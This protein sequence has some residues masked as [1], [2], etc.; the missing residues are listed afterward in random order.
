MQFNYLE[1]SR[2]LDAL[3]QAL[4]SVAAAFSKTKEKETAMAAVVLSKL[5]L[6]QLDIREKELD[7]L[8]EEANYNVSAKPL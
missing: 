3:A 2:R 1:E 4:C 5:M 8:A 6:N 7:K